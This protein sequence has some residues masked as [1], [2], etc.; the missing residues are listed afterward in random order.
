MY[1]H[2]SGRGYTDSKRKAI[3]RSLTTHRCNRKKHK[4][5][6]NLWEYNKRFNIYV[7]EIRKEEEKEDGAEKVFKVI[8]AQTS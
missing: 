3:L 8:T 5:P 2:W 1:I 7:I 4:E 6:Q